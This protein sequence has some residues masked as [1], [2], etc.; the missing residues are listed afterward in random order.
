M[1]KR[2]CSKSVP[3]QKCVT[4]Y[5]DI[6][7]EKIIMAYDLVFQSEFTTVHFNNSYFAHPDLSKLR[8]M[9]IVNNWHFTNELM[10]QNKEWWFASQVLLTTHS[11]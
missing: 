10:T 5:L 8:V 7:I 1:S 2:G 3:N 11:I 9:I 6:W 4:W